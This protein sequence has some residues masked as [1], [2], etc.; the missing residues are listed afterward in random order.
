MNTE[1]L[2][3][4]EW[5]NRDISD[6]LVNTEANAS[7]ARSSSN[8]LVIGGGVASALATLVAVVPAAAGQPVV[9]TWK[10]SCF[11]AAALSA[12]SGLC[13]TFNQA[14]GL[15]AFA[16]SCEGCAGRLKS[17]LVRA[18]S[19]SPNWSEITTEYRGIVSNYAR[20]MPSRP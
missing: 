6:Q 17:L 16:S 8:W 13:V 12:A 4:N 18:K 14:K 5:L 20:E 15:S 1:A 19:S 11:I 2:G 7:R 9:V 10:I 3:E